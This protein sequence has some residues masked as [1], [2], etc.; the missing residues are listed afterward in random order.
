MTLT[1]DVADRLTPELRDTWIS[2]L[3]KDHWAFFSHPDWCEAVW[4]HFGSTMSVRYLVAR[5]DGDAV[6]FLPVWTRRMNKFGL[7]LPITELFGSRR[8]DYAG[9]LIH[10]EAP[11]KTVLGA[12]LD[13]LVGLKGT[14]GSVIWPHMPEDHGYAEAF[15][16]LLD[17]RN[18]EYRREESLCHV[19][20]ID[21]SYEEIAAKW[22]RK[23]R[24]NVNRYRRKVLERFDTLSVV[25][26]DTPEEA[27]ERLPDFFEMHDYRWIEAGHPGTF[28]DP[29]TRAYFEDLVERFAGSH[30]YFSALMADD[31]PVAYRIGFVYGGYF[32]AF[33]SAF[34]WTLRKLSPGQVMNAETI[35]DGVERGWEGMDLLG[36][37]YDY[38]ESLSS[39]TVDRA[40]FYVRFG[41]VAPGYWWITRGRPAVEKHAGGLVYR[42][43]AG[44]DRLRRSLSSGEGDD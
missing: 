28:D 14:W 4:S 3:P 15:E 39:S 9:P 23:K 18:L 26:F 10:E 22:D 7:F 32:M 43:Q 27:R 17:E 1:V 6:G 29:D 12:L 19:V 5:D 34:D 24:Q 38:K 37:E 30:L 33:R 25:T 40:T 2:L 20:D 31:R 13:A 21:G 11:A 41:S 8:S 16:E 44:W 42:A 35:R 36:G